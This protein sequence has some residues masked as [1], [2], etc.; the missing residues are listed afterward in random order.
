MVFFEV[1]EVGLGQPASILKEIRPTIKIQP[2]LS[3][4]KETRPTSKHW[5]PW[6]LS[7]AKLVVSPKTNNLLSKVP[8]SIVISGN[9]CV[10]LEYYKCILHSLT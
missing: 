7:W 8:Y 5:K 2:S 6:A 10:L 3:V 9:Y 1:R 4:F